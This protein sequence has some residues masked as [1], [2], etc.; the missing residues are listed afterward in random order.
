MKR[1]TA[2]MA[3]LTL[4]LGGVGQA[5]A[6]FIITF[7]QVGNNVEVDGSGT[8]NLTD[9]TLKEIVSV[10]PAIRPN[11]AAVIFGPS[12]GTD[13]DTYGG[14]TGP[15][16]IGPG[17]ITFGTPGS[18]DAVGISGSTLTHDII[19]PS[20]YKSGASLMSNMSFGNTTISKL[21]LTPGTYKWTWGSAANG[22][23]DF[24]EVDIPSATGVPEPASLTLLGIGSLSLLGYGWRRR[25]RAAA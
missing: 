11:L 19:V 7:S 21:G 14:F 18:G 8:I 2:M 16:S 10:G 15:G 6:E 13:V 25:N 24:L 3:T 12:G 23:A 5:R 20:G 4:L 22:T 1:A 9:L 17:G